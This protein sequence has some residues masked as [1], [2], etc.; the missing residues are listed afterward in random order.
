MSTQIT[1]SA[2]R[3]SISKQLRKIGIVEKGLQRRLTEIKV[4]VAHR[5]HV[6]TRRVC[7]D[8]LR[9]LNRADPISRKQNH[10]GNVRLCAKAIHGRAAC[11][12]AS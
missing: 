9:A 3:K 11:V 12:A 10:N 5:K 1:G 7:G 8:H 2:K 6:Q 4:R